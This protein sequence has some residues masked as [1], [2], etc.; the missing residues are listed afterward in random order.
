MIA[1]GAIWSPSPGISKLWKGDQIQGMLAATVPE[2]R[3]DLWQIVDEVTEDGDLISAW[4]TFETT[5]ARGK[6]YLRLKAGKCW[7][8]LTTITELK[9]FE[10]KH[11]ATRVGGVR[12]RRRQEPKDLAG[13]KDSGRTGTW[14]RHPTLLRHHRR[15]TGRHRTGGEAETPGSSDARH[16]KEQPSRRFVAESLQIAL[17]A[18]PRVV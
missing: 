16:R 2:V 3:P 1:T 14:L 6:G 11:G 10:E 7:T 12:T 15:R 18:R 13:A 17:P 8:L 4:V 9:G 5:V